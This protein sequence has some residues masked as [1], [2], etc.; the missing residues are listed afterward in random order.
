MPTVLITGASRGLGLELARQYVE[1]GW[2]VIACARSPAKAADLGALAVASNVRMTVHP[3]DVTDHGQIEALA[4][5]LD[6]L[7]IDVLINSAG[8]MGRESFA[9]Q[10]MA[11]QRFG[12]T[13]YDDWMHTLR[14][15]VFG[16]MKLAEAFVENV[17]A[18]GQKKLVTLTS[19]VGSMGQ[20]TFGG[21]YAYRS[22]KAAA[23]CIMKSM[24]IDL[25]RRGIIALPMHPGWVRTEI[26]GPRGELDVATSV[27]GMLR[28]IEGL[29]PAQA[30][31]FLQ[32]DGR[33][34]PW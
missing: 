28:V 15:N 29:T 9:D 13:D 33:E 14:V 26:G 16:P 17:A 5:E 27:A 32:W 7:P 23:N 30:G 19:M 8:V 11:I 34:L 18:S 10:G 25:Q 31:R 6:G 21:L 12:Q 20:N 3:L 1:A 2:R 22:S 24:A 4:R